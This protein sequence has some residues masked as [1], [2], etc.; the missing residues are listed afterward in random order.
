M[1]PPPKPRGRGRAEMLS[2]DTRLALL[3]QADETH[4]AS[5]GALMG[6]VSEARRELS[7]ARSELAGLNATLAPMVSFYMD[8]VKHPR[9]E[10]PP[11]GNETIKLA[12]LVGIITV[13]AECLKLLITFMIGH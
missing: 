8:S 3:E 2:I 11:R 7:E 4:D 6:E 10:R 5:I 12:G 13:L 1:I 9:S